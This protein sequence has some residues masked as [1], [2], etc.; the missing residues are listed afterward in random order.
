[1]HVYMHTYVRGIYQ[2]LYVS[3]LS[4]LTSLSLSFSLSLFLSLSV[5]VYFPE[6][7]ITGVTLSRSLS[8]LVRKLE[9]TLH[10]L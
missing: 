10:G 7:L 6:V 8:S 3:P 1:M 4:S 5:G 2:R 9:V